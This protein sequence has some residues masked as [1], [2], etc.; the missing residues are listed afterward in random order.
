MHDEMGSA[1]KVVP[2]RKTY[3]ARLPVIPVLGFLLF[4]GTLIFGAWVGTQIESNRQATVRAAL[5]E[6]DQKVLAIITKKNP[7]AT[8]KDFLGFP[9]KLTGGAQDLGLDFRYVMALIDK[10]SEWN[11]RAVSPAGAIGLMQVMPET[12]ALVVRKMGWQGYEPPSPA[13]ASAKYAS[14]G[15]L[16]DPEWNLRIGMQFLRWQI[17]EFGLG[18]EHLRAYNRGGAQARANWPGDRYAEDVALRYVALAA[19]DS[20]VARHPVPLDRP[21]VGVAVATAPEHRRSPGFDPQ[22]TLIPDPVWIAGR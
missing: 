21:T 17:D 10:E 22:A 7:Q 4:C 15:S 5:S 3:S 16:G 9:E 20:R 13:K 1:V 12:A 11:P 8:I 6:R 2:I 18:P 14:L 19:M